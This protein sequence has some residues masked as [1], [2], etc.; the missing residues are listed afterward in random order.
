MRSYKSEDQNVWQNSIFRA[1]LPYCLACL[2]FY[3]AISWP[4]RQTRLH[5][6]KVREN[7]N[8]AKHFGPHFCT[9]SSFSLWLDFQMCRSWLFKWW[10]LVF[11]YLFIFVHFR[12]S[13]HVIS[14]FLFQDPLLGSSLMI[15][16]LLSSHQLWNP[17]FGDGYGGAQWQNVFRRIYTK[18]VSFIINLIHEL[19]M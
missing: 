1:I 5:M 16:E 18:K 17:F 11:L 19:D 2:N 3:T 14:P 13:L 8:S 15:I 4:L 10:T 12:S 9:T 6:A 7:S